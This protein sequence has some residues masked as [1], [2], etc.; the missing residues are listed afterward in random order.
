MESWWHL[1]VECT[2]KELGTDLSSGLSSN[3]AAARIGK[4]GRNQLQ[5]A[6]KRA[7]LAIFLDQFK[8]FV[9]WI[10]IG[11]AVGDGARQADEAVG[12]PKARQYPQAELA[13]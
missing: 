11:A 5:E 1:D 9:I 12:I 3:E 4:Y 7:P 2:A 13:S 10:L 6:P 8:D